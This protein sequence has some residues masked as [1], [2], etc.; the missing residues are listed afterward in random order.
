VGKKKILIKDDNDKLMEKE[1]ER[2]IMK[3]IMVM[4]RSVRKWV[5]R[6]RFLKMS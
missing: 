5:C 6:K 3:R 4:K 2:I 1:R